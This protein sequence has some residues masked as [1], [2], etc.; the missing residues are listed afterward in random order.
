MDNVRLARR[1]YFT[2]SKAPVAN[3]FMQKVKYSK[4]QLQQGFD[5]LRNTFGTIYGALVLTNAFFVL[6]QT[7]LVENIAISTYPTSREDQS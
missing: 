3:S 4:I 7:V 2:K 6:G 1:I 5:S